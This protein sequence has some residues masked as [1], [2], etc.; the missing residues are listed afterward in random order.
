MSIL[1]RV[2][3]LIDPL[4][5]PVK[6]PAFTAAL[7]LP[8][9]V[10]RRL[11]GK[12]VTYDGQTLAVDTQI[13]LALMKVSGEPDPSTLPI[14]KGRVALLRQS[15][16]GGG[17][18][19]IGSVRELWAAGLKARLY[20]PEGASGNAPL[21]VFLHGGGFI[22]GDLDSHDAPCRLLASESGVKVLSVDY[23]L[24]PE[25]P[26]PAAYDDSVA[27]FRW[28][29]EHAA[30]LGADPAR[31]GVGGDSAGGNLAAGVALAVGEDC[32]FQL[33]IYP[34][35]QSEANT[36]S[37]EDL[38]EGFYLTADFIGAAT[39]NYLPE[40]IDRRDPRHAPLY[41]EIPATGVAP[42]Y[43]ATAGFDPLRD[44]GEAYAAK[45]DEAGVKVVHRRF[46][47][48]IHGFLN[49]VG[50]GRTSR[51]AVLEIAQVL[52]DNL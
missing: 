45:L 25:S 49:V 22:F 27:A 14:P 41:A 2:S 35:T 9:P 50:A 31:I 3:S 7:N 20:V 48:Q 37:R 16:L 44:E 17:R 5:V 46:D 11:V 29:V 6:R 47:D 24:A 30:E 4:L 34:V 32:A 1:A 10:Q 40:D 52:R 18:Q 21:L 8:A 15:Q 28:A 12:P 23:R 33:L 43:V 26:F 13:M 36:R 42:A 19:E 39:S 51:A 38:S